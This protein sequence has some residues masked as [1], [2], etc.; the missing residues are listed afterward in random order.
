MS[1]DES[2]YVNSNVQ[3]R[4]N[5]FFRDISFRESEHQHRFLSQIASHAIFVSKKFSRRKLNQTMKRPRSFDFKQF[6]NCLILY[7]FS[8][9]LT[10]KFFTK[11]DLGKFDR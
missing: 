2:Y 8:V 9:L 5:R 6:L 11:G 3:M 7:L 1:N 4:S 10:T